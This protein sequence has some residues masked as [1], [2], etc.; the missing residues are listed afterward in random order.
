[1]KNADPLR[2]ITRNKNPD[3]LTD[4]ELLEILLRLTAKDSCGLAQR[5]MEIYPSVPALIEADISDL[6]KIPGMDEESLLLLRLLPEMQRR[7]FLSR[8]EKAKRLLSGADYGHY[9]LPYYF[10]ARDE[11]VYLL[12][13]DATGNVLNCR[14]MGQGTVCSANV[15]MRRLVQEALTANASGIVLAHN[16]PSGMAVPSKEDVELTLRIRDS[17]SILDL[18]L[19]DHIIIADD[20]FISLRESGY[21]QT[22][23]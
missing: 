3:A 1:M 13:L 20:D 17:L 14:F 2:K 9:L 15:P 5:I 11:I 4:V 12:L 19:L 7:Y 6:F 16:H 10:G 22:D 8:N 18:Q 23:E 21:L